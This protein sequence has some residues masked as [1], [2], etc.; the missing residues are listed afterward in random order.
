MIFLFGSRPS[1]KLALNIP[2]RDYA[3]V[4]FTINTVIFSKTVI[5]FTLTQSCSRIYIFFQ[6][7]CAFSAV[8]DTKRAYPSDGRAFVITE[9]MYQR[10]LKKSYINN[11]HLTPYKKTSKI[12]FFQN[13]SMANNNSLKI[14]CFHSKKIPFW[15]R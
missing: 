10:H 3:H 6:Y 12:L 4:S 5:Y 13:K 2:T 8:S 9:K 15:Q 7:D 11:D 1:S 14:N